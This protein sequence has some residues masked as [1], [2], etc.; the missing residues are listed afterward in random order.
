MPTLPIR[1]YVCY[2]EP[3]NHHPGDWW[4]WYLPYTAIAPSRHS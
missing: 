4:V 2:Y 3:T 1:R